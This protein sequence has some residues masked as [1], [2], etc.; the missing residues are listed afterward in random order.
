MTDA[1]PFGEGKIIIELFN[2]KV[3]EVLGEE[4]EVDKKAKITAAID[5]KK[6]PAK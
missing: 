2:K 6:K 5:A 1:I 3:I 4:T